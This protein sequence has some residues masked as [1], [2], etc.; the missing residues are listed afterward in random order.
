M[1]KQ[2]NNPVQQYLEMGEEDRAILYFTRLKETKQL[3]AEIEFNKPKVDYYD[4]VMDE[5]GLAKAGDIASKFGLTTKGF[6]Q[7][8]K[9]L[10]IQYK[11]GGIWYLYVK[12]KGKGYVDYPETEYKS[13]MRWTKK[14]VKFVLDTLK[15]YGYNSEKR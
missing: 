4:L 13:F 6:N 9:D 2:L 11:Q 1:E 14:G 5:Q 12:H 7:I 8:L 10:K 3:K 15:A